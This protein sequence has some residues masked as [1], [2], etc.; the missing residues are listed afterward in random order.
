MRAAT[1]SLE[2][3]IL[4]LPAAIAGARAAPEAPEAEAAAPQK[5]R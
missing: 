4:P 2:R 1:S 5:G 3:K